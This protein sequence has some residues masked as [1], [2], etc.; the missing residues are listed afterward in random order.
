M[1]QPQARKRRSDRIQY[2]AQNAMQADGN[3]SLPNMA[4]PQTATGVQPRFY[5]PQGQMPRGQMT[6]TQMPQGQ[7]PQG[8]MPQGQMSP[9]AQAPLTQS[10]MMQR[11]MPQAA[12]QPRQPG[13]QQV[14]SQG[15]YQQEAWANSRQMQPV[16]R[17]PA[18]MYPPAQGQGASQFS[19]GQLPPNYQTGAVPPQS[20]KWHALPPAPP[21]RLRE[22]DM[23]SRRLLPS[24]PRRR[25]FGARRRFGWPR[26][27]SW[28]YSSL[29]CAFGA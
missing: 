11:Q 26:W 21:R 8:Q 23:E 13:G 19:G 25:R 9:G 10:Q 7:A 27:F 29:C 2:D 5:P 18:R 17:Q 28:G 3:V 6:Q 1:E 24:R 15:G 12:P 4:A 22:A 14:Y 16:V 20:A